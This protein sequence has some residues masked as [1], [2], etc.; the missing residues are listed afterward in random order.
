MFVHC[1]HNVDLDAGNLDGLRLCH[2]KKVCR[3]DGLSKLVTLL[4][5]RRCRY[6]RSKRKM[7]IAV[8]NSGPYP[9]HNTVAIT[10]MAKPEE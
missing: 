10:G 9:V 3:T 8:V 5:I 1:I 4:P 7:G 2:G 6:E